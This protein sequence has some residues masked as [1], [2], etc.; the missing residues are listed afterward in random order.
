MMQQTVISQSVEK[1]MI[2]LLSKFD[3]FDDGQKN[4][5]DMLN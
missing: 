3:N 1:S 2:F 4:E 5:F